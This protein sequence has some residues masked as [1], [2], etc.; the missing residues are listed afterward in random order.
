MVKSFCDLD[1]Y[2]YFPTMN[3]A[4]SPTQTMKINRNI[5]ENRQYITS[6]HYGNS[7]P[8]EDGADIPLLGGAG[9]PLLIS[10]ISAPLLAAGLKEIPLVMLAAN[11]PLAASAREA[12]LL[13]A[14]VR[15]RIDASR[16]SSSCK[17]IVCFS[18]WQN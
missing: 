13:E 4:K 9:N 12:P 5:L 10:A 15:A 18:I 14:A 17:T 6:H 11:C 2:G 8:L 7:L 3:F 1:L 16:F